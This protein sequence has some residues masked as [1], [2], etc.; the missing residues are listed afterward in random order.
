MERWQ[1]VK[2]AGMVPVVWAD[3]DGALLSH[4]LHGLVSRIVGAECKMSNAFQEARGEPQNM[5][6]RN[7]AV[8]SC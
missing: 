7:F 2:H 4:S 8:Q 1:L 5:R 6:D 3:R